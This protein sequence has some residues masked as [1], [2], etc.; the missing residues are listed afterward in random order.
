MSVK[1]AKIL[2]VFLIFLLC[3]P[4]HF[5]YKWLPNSLFSILFPVNESIF[6]HM[7]MMFTAIISYGIIDYF[8]LRKTKHHNFLLALFVSAISSIFIYLIIYLPIY[9]RMGENMFIS[10]SLL[11]IVIM[12]TQIISYYILRMKDLNLDIVSIIL[13]VISYIVLAY[14]T[15]NP[16]KNYVFFDTEDE[17]YGINDYQI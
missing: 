10:I 4:Y 1:K 13:I 9:N 16:I 2:A 8:V 3:F 5:I 6:E 12:I 14:L 11:F 7:K 15:Y 17:K